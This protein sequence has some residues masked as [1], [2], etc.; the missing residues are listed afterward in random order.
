[1]A[2]ICGHA[3]NNKHNASPSF[4]GQSYAPPVRRMWLEDAIR[5]TRHLRDN[6]PESVSAPHLPTKPSLFAHT[7]RFLTYVM[8]QLNTISSPEIFPEGD[9]IGLLWMEVGP[10][11]DKSFSA[12][13]RE[14]PEQGPVVVVVEPKDAGTY[15]LEDARVLDVMR[16]CNIVRQKDAL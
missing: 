12:E 15:S 14:D 3:H 8:K 7:E 16:R 11:P 13:I 4:S 10:E 2:S 6:F 1:M 5:F 9:H